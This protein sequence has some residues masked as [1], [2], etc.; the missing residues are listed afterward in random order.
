[1]KALRD[2]ARDGRRRWCAVAGVA[3]FAALTSAAGTSAISPP[4]SAQDGPTPLTCTTGGAITPESEPIPIHLVGPVA[5]SLGAY[6]KTPP[7]TADPNAVLTRL[8]QIK[9]EQPE[10]RK[11][12]RKQVLEWEAF[13]NASKPKDVEKVNN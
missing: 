5:K 1:M 7:A 2:I 12:W 3:A 11:G 6:L 9:V 8:R 10:A 4:A 13:A